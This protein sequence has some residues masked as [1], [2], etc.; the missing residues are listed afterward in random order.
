MHW[1]AVNTKP[2]REHVAD[3]NL[4]RLGVETFCPLLKQSKVIRRR[5][6]TVVG[7]LFPAYLF[8]RFNYEDQQRAVSYARGV[9]KIVVFGATPAVVEEDLIDAIKSR[10]EN[11]YVT[12]TSPRF[13]PGES[14]RIQEG[15][16]CGLEAIFERDM[17][18]HQRVVLLLRTLA[19]QAR[20]VVP[21][22][23]VAHL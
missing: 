21:F 22:D 20:V 8:I 6:Q 4:R 10:L 14:V 9:R 16:L 1:Y 2:Y 7:P 15:P 3:L 19:Y 5:R 17:S 11:G 23:Q 13:T 12:V 18:H